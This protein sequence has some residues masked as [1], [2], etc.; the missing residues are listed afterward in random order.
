MM[1]TKQTK[2][3]HKSVVLDRFDETGER[4]ST[5]Y[6]KRAAKGV[7]TPREERK[8]AKVGVLPSE[9]PVETVPVGRN[10]RLFT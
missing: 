4:R 5:E 7:R 3:L 10:R 2:S 9:I 8:M 6:E 1:Q